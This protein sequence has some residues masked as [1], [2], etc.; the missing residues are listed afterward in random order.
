MIAAGPGTGKSAFILNWAYRCPEMRTLYLSA[1]SDAATQYKRLGS[2]V[3]NYSSDYVEQQME[4]HPEELSEL[5]GSKTSHLQFDFNPYPD[6]EDIANQVSAYAEVYGVYPDLIVMDNAK[7]LRLGDGARSGEFD[8]LE[9]NMEFLQLVARQTNAAVVALHH[10]IGTYESGDHP[11]PLSGIRG[12]L[13]KTPETVLTIFRGPG[14][15]Y[16]SPVKN[17]DGRGDS[18]GNFWVALSTDLSRMSF[19]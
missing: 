16:I 14:Q 17:R 18:S 2:M 11:I 6:G 1:D 19:L 10:V 9:G 4:H 5:I 7:N 12:K 13:S 15:S 3:T 8:E